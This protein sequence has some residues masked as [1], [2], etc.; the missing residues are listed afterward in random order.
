MRGF[1]SSG[2]RTQLKELIRKDQIDITF[3]QETIKQDF[4][5]QELCGLVW[6]KLYHWH[7]HPAEGWSNGK[8][9]GIREAMF[10]VGAI[11]QGQFFF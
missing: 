2:H 3:L 11:D 4:T 9:M 5:D 8:L 1:G 10:E 6:R 7:W